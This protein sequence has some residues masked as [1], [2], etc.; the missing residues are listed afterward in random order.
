MIRKIRTM[1]LLGTLI[2]SAACSSSDDAPG[3]TPNPGPGQEP[4]E[5]SKSYTDLRVVSYNVRVD[6]SADGTNAWT[7]R[8]EGA[9]TMI[10]RELPVVMGLQ[11]AQAHQITYLAQNCPDYA[12]YGLGRDTAAVPPETLSYSREETMAIFY[13]TR[14]VELQDKGTF[15]LSETPDK[16]SKGWDANYNRTCT[17]GQF[18]HKESGRIF[19]FFNTHLDD[20]GKVAREESVKLLVA[21]MKEINPRR[22]PSFLTGD[23]NSN[24]TDAIFTPLFA[25]MNDARA[26]APVTDNRATW[27]DYTG[28]STAKYDHIFYNGD[29]CT[30]R[31]YRTLDGDYGVPYLSDHY[32]VA[33]VFR[34]QD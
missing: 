26:K 16:V 24:T 29:N 19:F 6:N 7:Y 34:L 14:A 13:D 32:P 25:Y 20:S 1:L 17:W 5:P 15:W 8:K 31:E 30:A 9:V 27:N 11:E 10:G 21:K 2:A 4:Q 23:F 22:R 28:T 12:W 18:R 33:A 3:E